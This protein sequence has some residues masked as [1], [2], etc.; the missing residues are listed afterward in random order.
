M[1]VKIITRK[2]AKALGLSRYFTG[3]SCKYGH[4]SEKFLTGNCVQ[5]S[6]RINWNQERFKKR[7]DYLKKRYLTHPYHSDIE[8]ARLCRRKWDKENPEKRKAHTIV[9]LAIRHGE[10]TVLPCE[11]CGELKVHG[12]HDDYSKPL[13]VRWLCPIHHKEHHSNRG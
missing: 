5:C 4:I 12:H 6:L 2:E 13:K 9:T 10:L 7:R 3:K 8:K 11:K 1:S